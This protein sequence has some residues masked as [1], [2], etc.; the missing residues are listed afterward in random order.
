MPSKPAVPPATAVRPAVPLDQW[1]EKTLLRIGELANLLG[2]ETHVVRF[3]TAEFGSVRPERSSTNRLLYGRA[4]AERLFRI[5]TLL[6]EKGMT[7]AGARK[8]LAAPPDPARAEPIDADYR[9]RLEAQAAEAGRAVERLHTAL[10][11]AEAREHAARAGEA[12]ARVQLAARAAL[13]PTVDVAPLQ[14]LTERIRAAA[15]HWRNGAP[16]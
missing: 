10:R 8:A 1:P 13:A 7:I 15:R 16:G 12:E 5:R 4:A 6:Y 14:A 3:W 2:V 9:V 11:A